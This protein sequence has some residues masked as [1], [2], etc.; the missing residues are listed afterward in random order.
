MLQKFIETEYSSP[1]LPSTSNH[2]P[3]SK[4]DAESL[5][6]DSSQSETSLQQ[7]DQLNESNLEEK[8]KNNQS[9][10]CL[11]TV[12]KTGQS[13]S[14]ISEQSS[15]SELCLQMNGNQ[16]QKSKTQKLENSESGTNSLHV[17]FKQFLDAPR[18]VSELFLVQ[19]FCH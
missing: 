18:F 8:Q 6:Q 19:L 12:T 11:Q 2:C 14:G 3:E 9:D 7:S 4:D 5:D 16:S 15:A 10:G 1:E 13:N 17:T